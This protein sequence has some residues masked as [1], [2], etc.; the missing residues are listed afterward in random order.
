MST[1]DW[2][3]ISENDLD[4]PDTSGGY[5]RSYCQCHHDKRPRSLSI[6]L[7]NGFG[8]CFRCGTRV[9]VREI[10]PQAVVNIT[11][12]RL[13]NA[14][15]VIKARRAIPT[16][17]REIKKPM[18]DDWQEK[19]LAALR[20]LQEQVEAQLDDE[21]ARAYLAGRGIAFETAKAL[22][23]GYIPIENWDAPSWWTD[24]LI[25]PTYSPTDGLQFVGRSLQC[26][27]PGMD[28][29]QHKELLEKRGIKRWRKTTAEG[30]FNFGVLETATN[31]TIV[32]GSF[33]ALA[34]IE[35]GQVNTIAVIG[36]SV[37]VGWLPHHLK[38]ITLAFDGDSSG[39][40]KSARARNTLYE[41]G[42]NVT[43]CNAPQDDWSQ[44]YRLHGRDGLAVLIGDKCACGLSIFDDH[45]IGEF[46]QY[47][48]YHCSVCKRM[49]DA[50]HE[51]RYAIIDQKG[52]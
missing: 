33:D 48:Y 21:R 30:Y 15:G 10:N 17:R 20:D 6:N 52:A 39:I 18:V 2:T 23:V 5:I 8:H 14:L 42:Y 25:F 50:T 11:R 13:D 38:H 36:T 16:P 40:E 24:T 28:E 37:Q 19:E 49:E 27:E 26:W 46:D 31:V 29:M 9:L 7:E 1:T 43:I 12:G 3:I 45:E 41:R 44:L 32:E 22:H 35:A 47:G 34:L 51:V 4:D